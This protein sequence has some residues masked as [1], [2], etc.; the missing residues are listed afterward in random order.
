ME[1]TK[2]THTHTHTGL[3]VVIQNACVLMEKSKPLLFSSNT[4]CCLTKNI[5]IAQYPTPHPHPTHTQS[6]TFSAVQILHQMWQR[7]DIRGVFAAMEKMS[8]HAV[9][10]LQ[11]LFVLMHG[12]TVRLIIHYYNLSANSRYLL[13]WQVL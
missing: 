2:H 4:K 8:D 5:E 9:S 12:T 3:T 13:I 10:T 11:H 7:N 6:L 1:R